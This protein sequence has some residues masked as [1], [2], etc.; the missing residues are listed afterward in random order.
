V[1]EL[2]KRLQPLAEKSIQITHR[3]SI[4]EDTVRT[5]DAT[6]ASHC[7]VIDSKQYASFLVDFFLAGRAMKTTVTASGLRL[8]E[9][10]S[11]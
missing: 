11:V 1:P 5:A 6:F 10:S 9:S 2:R 8:I 4:F 7:T 3:Y